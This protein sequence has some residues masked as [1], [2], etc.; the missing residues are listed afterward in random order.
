MTP[1]RDVD[2]LVIGSGLAGLTYAL[3]TAPHGSTLILTKKNRAESNTNYAQG[4]I[5]GVMTDEDDVRLHA[6]DTM[7]AGAGLCHPDAVE[8][9][10]TE[11]PER[12]RDLI[13]LGARF[14]TE[15]DPHGHEILAL[16]REGGHSRNRIVH[17]VDRTGWECERAQLEASHNVPNLEILEHYFVTDLAVAESEGGGE[18]ARGRGGES[19][20][21]SK[22]Q[23]PKFRRCVGAWA[24]D[25][26]T[27]EM[28]L[29]RARIV[30]LATGGCGRVYKHTTNPAIATGDGVAMAWRAG[31][32]IANM[33]FIQFHPTALYHPNGDSFLISEAVR[34]EGGILRAADGSTFMERYDPRKELAP[35]DIVARAI[36]AERLKRGEP[37]VYLDITHLDADFI[38]RR[39]PTIYETCL[40]L[41]LDITCEPIP[42]VPAAHYMCGGVLTDLDGRTTLP[43]LYAAGEVACTGVHGANRLA[44]N[45]LLEAMVFG[46]RA[47][48]KAID[49]HHKGHGGTQRI[50]E[51][52]FGTEPAPA[53]DVAAARAGIRAVMNDFV[54]IVRNDRD[55]GIAREQV[56]QKVME[57]DVL[58]RTCR[59][60]PDTH[61]LRNMAMVAC[62]I[63]RSALSRKESRGLHYTTDYPETDDLNWKHDTILENDTV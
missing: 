20:P 38:R 58:V 39:F 51:P 5:A 30:L 54:G 52:E 18:G 61:E 31:A 62:L 57:A 21:E 13:R 45:S 24:L 6:Q 11:G 50:Q 14:S 9:L 23:N 36:H 44:S 56:W 43:G 47:A 28:R 33:E 40:K 53:E 32:A 15:K 63:T 12:I 34:G 46:W 60:D 35:R 8:T 26:T 17:A 55:L 16:G 48:R 27:G 41:G 49:S 19:N 29:F 2:F 59:P 42:V 1:V 10:V 25:T 7:I 37:C 4:G 22:I 3:Q